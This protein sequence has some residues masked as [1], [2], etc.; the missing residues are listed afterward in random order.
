MSY[1]EFVNLFHSDRVAF[2]RLLHSHVCI[3][4]YA[5]VDYSG[6]LSH[7]FYGEDILKILYKANI[8]REPLD[9]TFTKI[10]VGDTVITKYNSLGIVEGFTPKGYAKIRL[11][12]SGRLVHREPEKITIVNPRVDLNI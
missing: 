12:G 4:H 11:K 1:N 5:L 6:E 9:N 3:V 2:Y 8:L 7:G 10:S